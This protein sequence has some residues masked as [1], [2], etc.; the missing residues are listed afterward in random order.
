[1]WAQSIAYSI[2]TFQLIAGWPQRFL[3]SETVLRSDLIWVSGFNLRMPFPR[4]SLCIRSRSDFCFAPMHGIAKARL[5]PELCKTSRRALCAWGLRPWTGIRHGAGLPV[6]TDTTVKAGR[7]VNWCQGY[8]QSSWAVFQS[9][10]DTVR[11][12]F[13]AWAGT[14]ALTR[15]DLASADEMC[16]SRTGLPRQGGQSG[17]AHPT[18]GH[19]FPCSPRKRKPRLIC[20]SVS[21]ISVLSHS[22]FFRL[23]IL[24]RSR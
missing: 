18:R 7:V 21:L 2:R 9:V 4:G 6:G 3:L 11:H 20:I 19:R 24:M 5:C 12:G 23:R 8:F 22:N 1:M 10:L 13:G 15:P 14:A 16:R 17:C